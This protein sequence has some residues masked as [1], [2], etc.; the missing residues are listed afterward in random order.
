[1]SKTQTIL[2]TGA[3]DG[4]GR[5]IAFDL[6]AKGYSL[7]LHGRDHAKGDAL[8]KNI[9][10][11]TGNKDL[12]Y[13]NADFASISAIKQLA[14]T[15]LA[16]H[17]RLHVLI[18]NAGLGVEPHRRISKDGYEMIFQVDYLSTYLLSKLLLP[19]L[20]A[21]RPARIVNVASAGQAPIDFS[22]P[23]Q[24]KHWD[25]V[26]SYC[27]AKLAQI[28]LG[29]E[30]GN[31][32]KANGVTINSLHPASYMPTK[33]VTNLYTPQSTLQDGIDAVVNLALNTRLADVSGKYFNRLQETRALAQA[34][35]PKARQQLIGLSAKLTGI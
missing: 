22:D 26:Q 12:F 29:I 20:Q 17:T 27:Q 34:Y 24:E 31:E 9:E 35:D 5:G 1:M 8:I 13:Y 21:S 6:A 30:W 3:T 18:N 14:A 16:N 28:M 4:L 32:Q 33:I 23:L 7:I 2:I 19:L 11:E 25:G 10:K 15:V